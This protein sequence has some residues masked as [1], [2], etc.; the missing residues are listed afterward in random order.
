MTDP[1]GGSG[2]GKSFAS[3]DPCASIDEE[4]ETV[5]IGYT[6]QA[7]GVGEDQ[8]LTV[9]G[10]H[11]RWNSG[12]YRWRLAAGGGSLSAGQGY[13]VVYT[14]P[15]SNPDCENNATINLVCEGDVVDQLSIA[16]N[17]YM[18]E[19]R[20]TRTWSNLTCVKPLELFEIY[21]CKLY[22]NTY[23]CAGDL[24]EDFPCLLERQADSCEACQ[25]D[26]WPAACDSG[27][28]TMNYLLEVTPVD[29]RTPLMIEQGCC[30]ELWI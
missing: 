17:A 29:L 16:I 21:N 19:E 2:G 10:Y 5:K 22:N 20:A 28:N 12:N 27:N 15:A 14:A 7:M 24:M 25:E 13:S 23:N 6:T 9:E 18:G 4:F 11:P 3:G 8:T 30:P 1:G 26:I